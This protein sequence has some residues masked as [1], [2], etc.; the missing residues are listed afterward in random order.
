MWGRPS[1]LGGA[2]VEPRRFLRSLFVH[3]A[4][5]FA[6]RRP[7]PHE[8]PIP[9]WRF[10]ARACAHTAQLQRRSR[11]HPPLAFVRPPRP[12]AA[13]SAALPACLPPAA[14]QGAKARVAGRKHFF[15]ATSLSPHT[16]QRAA[17]RLPKAAHAHT[18]MCG[19]QLQGALIRS[20]H[21][22]RFG[23]AMRMPAAMR[24]LR[25]PQARPSHAKALVSQL[26]LVSCAMRPPTKADAHHH[27]V[28]F[29][30]RP[31]ARA[32]A[33]RCL[34]APTHLVLGCY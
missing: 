31:G 19:R 22:P 11:P 9:L 6:T 15:Q 33:P 29:H 25:L 26:V 18:R 21:T 17:Q 2:A 24:A 23:A 34:P 3:W 30:P 20:L 4:A 16:R 12:R 13:P 27:T 1:I 14:Q 10:D 8:L 7:P 28:T 32:Q 5:R